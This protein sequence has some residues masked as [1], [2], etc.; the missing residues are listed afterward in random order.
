MRILNRQRSIGDV[1]AG[2]QCAIADAENTIRT[3]LRI[4]AENDVGFN[5]H[6]VVDEDPVERTGLP[7]LE[8]QIFGYGHRGFAVRPGLDAD[9]RAVYDVGFSQTAGNRLVRRRRRLAVL[10]IVAP[11]VN[12]ANVLRLR[13]RRREGDKQKR[14]CGRLPNDLQ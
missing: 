12:V 13:G 2:A 11:R 5:R 9:D 8:D 7:C 14:Q 3:C 10:G 4:L 6:A 1:Q